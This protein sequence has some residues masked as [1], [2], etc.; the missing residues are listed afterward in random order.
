MKSIQD[1]LE[2]YG[3]SDK[4]IKVYLACLEL[5]EGSVLT[6]AKRANIKRPTTYL[7]LEELMKRGM[8]D[9]RKTQKGLLYRALHPKKIA[10]Q[11]K[12]LSQEYDDVLPDILSIY[13]SKE[14]KPVIGVYEDYDMY[15]Q[16]AN[17]VREY[18]DTGKEALFFGN[19]EYFYSYPSLVKKWFTVMKHK[20]TKCREILC[21]LGPVQKEYKQKVEALENPNYQVRLMEPAHEVVTEFGVWGN[22]VVLFSGEGKDLYTITIEGEHQANTQRAIFEQLWSSLT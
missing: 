10:T 5:G 18:V 3:L 14:D 7:V 22:K 15:T 2:H 16:I 20:R 9:S 13:H 11:I 6:L 1:F 8:V 19:S 4:E 12:N 17:E 21:G